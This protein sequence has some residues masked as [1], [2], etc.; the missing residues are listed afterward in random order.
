MLYGLPLVSSFTWMGGSPT[1]IY[2]MTE[3]FVNYH[4]GF[5]KRGLFG[6]MLT[7]LGYLSVQKML[8]LQFFVSCAAVALT[9]AVFWCDLR[10]GGKRM[11]AAL[12]L[13]CSPAGLMHFTYIVAHPDIVVYMLLLAAFVCLT[14]LPDGWAPYAALV[15]CIVAILVHEAFLLLFYPVIA[16]ILFHGYIHKRFTRTAVLVHAVL[17][18]SAFALVVKLGVNRVDPHVLLAEAQARTD[19][20]LDGK[21][22]TTLSRSLTEQ[23]TYLARAYTALTLAGLI[24]SLLCL[25]PYIIGSLWI[26]K[27]ENDALPRPLP[28]WT[29]WAL[30]A[31][32]L[33]LCFLGHDVM[34]WL[35]GS[36]VC[37]FLYLV[38]LVRTSEDHEHLTDIP[39]PFSEVY[40]PL[41]LFGL[42][43]GPMG[44]GGIHMLGHIANVLMGRKLY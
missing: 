38:Y 12:L 43:V 16:A 7:H 31:I 6:E 2:G 37:V 34:R 20:P 15:P 13:I 26:L 35:A 41:I 44:T 8:I 11:L 24:A 17:F 32:P 18:A 1:N 36:M 39:N 21:I 22:F 9:Y 14:R 4:H 29:P 27:T 30:F 19:L 40:V 10:S 33:L 5:V 28:R 23:W 3:Y 42:A 25:C